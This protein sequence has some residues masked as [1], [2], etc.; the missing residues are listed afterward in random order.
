LFGETYVSNNFATITI[1]CRLAIYHWKG[2]KEGYKFVV[3][4][5]SI[6]IFNFYEKNYDHTKIQTHSL[7]RGRGC[8]MGQFTSLLFRGLGK[9]PRPTMCPGEHGFKLP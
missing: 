8:S 4:R 9:I 7:L 5:T 1:S 6:R 2:F 3:Q